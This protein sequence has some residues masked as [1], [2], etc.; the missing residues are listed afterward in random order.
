MTTPY[1]ISRCREEAGVTAPELL[2]IRRSRKGCV[3]RLTVRGELDIAT[4]PILEQA[5]AAVLARDNVRMI[6]VDLAKLTFMDSS[7]LHLL[8]RMN[9]ACGAADRLRIVNGSQAVVRLLDLSGVGE[10][11]PIISSDRDPLVPLPRREAGDRR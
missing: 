4:V 7:G 9:D 3:E 8:L 11:L 6:V 1:L 2:S 5:F 10:L